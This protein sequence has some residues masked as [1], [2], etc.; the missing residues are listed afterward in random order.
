MRVRGP[1]CRVPSAE[2][3]PH[4]LVA[5]AARSPA[6]SIWGALLTATSL[7]C[8]GPP[9]PPPA[10]PASATFSERGPIL[11]LGDTQ[12]TFWLERL[13]GGFIP[14]PGWA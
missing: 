6:W 7:A 2:R 3:A 13:I 9:L 8:D 10:P 11:V 5:G 4:R 12:R 1:L 14:P